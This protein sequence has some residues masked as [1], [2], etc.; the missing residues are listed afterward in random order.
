MVSGVRATLAR[1]SRQLVSEQEV[2]WMGTLIAKKYPTSLFAKAADH[3][4]VEC[5]T[6][7]KGWGCWGGKAGGNAFRQGTGSTAR[8]AA[9][10]QPNEKAGIRC[11]LVNGVCHQ[12]ANRILIPTGITVL[13]ARGYQ[14]SQLMYG[15]YGRLGAFPCRSPFHQHPGVGGDLPECAVAGA[16]E[17]NGGEDETAAYDVDEDE[18][19]LNA[20][21]LELYS[22]F[23]PLF[24]DEVEPASYAEAEEFDVEHFRVVLEHRLDG[25]DASGQA[26]LLG[27]RRET[28]ERQIYLES[29]FA[30]ESLDPAAFV[31]ATNGI[32]LTFQVELARSLSDA[33]YE[34][35]VGLPKD[36]PIV[37]ADPEIADTVRA[38]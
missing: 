11:Y 21:V 22:G 4:Y 9:I 36:E 10:A 35:L 19:A 15:T 6:G 14:L 30:N 16:G 33:A 18:A 26:G 3:T 27:V 7:A 8:A 2:T 17:A 24:A 13:G 12:A 23:A 38:E 5:G 29:Q 20:S 28:S 32:T 25:S 31:D 37:L 1:S 34:K